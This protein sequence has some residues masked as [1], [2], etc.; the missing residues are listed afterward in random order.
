MTTK[1]TSFGLM[2]AASD[3]PGTDDTGLYA[4]MLEDARLG[5][6]LGFGGA[7]V[8]E[9]HFSSYFPQPSPLMILSHIAAKYPDF[10]LGT[11]VTVTP[12]HHPLRLA[13]EI[14][15]LSHLTRGRLHLGLGR[16]NAQM[17]YDAFDIDMATAKD[18]F[19]DTWRILE[20]AMTG[21]PITYQGK[22]LKA[23][24]G[25]PIR[26]RPRHEKIHFY[27]GMWQ[28][29]SAAKI[30]DLGLPPMCNGTR[31]MDEHRGVLKVWEDTARARNDP[32]DVTKVVA[33][34]LIVADTDEEAYELG[35][36]YM[37]RWFQAQA[38]HYQHDVTRNRDLPDYQPFAKMQANRVL[39]SDP[40]NI[41]PFLDV[42]LV[43][44]P[45]TIKKRLQD[46]IDIGF[47]YII[48]LTNT[49]GIPSDIRKGW[50]RRFA[51][52]IAP[53]FSEDFRSRRAA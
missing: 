1:N 23:P 36:R 17:E 26:P 49:P 46:Y 39:M 42:C 15:E 31:P 48:I 29:S 5:Y 27:G 21:E 7:W 18:R 2:I 12:W 34:N 16:G 40:A 43:G 6:E 24:R 11:M 30:A 37:T 9:H 52:E 41:G 45:K 3:T 33:C 19:E 10:D 51:Q 14:A 50:L 4:A 35:R 38:E 47:N 32:T 8:I 22:I 28:A 53:E 44:S 25:V 20:M 13:G